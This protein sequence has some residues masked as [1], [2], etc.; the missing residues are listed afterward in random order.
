MQKIQFSVNET[1]V[2]ICSITSVCINYY[3]DTGNPAM[4][5]LAK[6]HVHKI[7]GLVANYLTFTFCWIQVILTFRGYQK[8]ILYVGLHNVEIR[9]FILHFRHHQKKLIDFNVVKTSFLKAITQRDTCSAKL[10]EALGIAHSPRSHR[11]RLIVGSF[12]MFNI[13]S[14]HCI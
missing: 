6:L 14:G 7:G 2:K 1:K 9:W 4:A 10:S 5:F 13:Q 3:P 12:C 11:E 8:V